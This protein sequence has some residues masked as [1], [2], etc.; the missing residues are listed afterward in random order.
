MG[1]TNKLVDSLYMVSIWK[2][3]FDYYDLFVY[4][5]CTLH[6]GS[7]ARSLCFSLGYL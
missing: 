1:G 4:I 5:R 6:V 7:S 3:M 2:G